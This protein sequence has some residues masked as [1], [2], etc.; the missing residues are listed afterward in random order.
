[1]LP[2]CPQNEPQR[3]VTQTDTD[4]IPITAQISLDLDKLPESSAENGAS[5]ALQLAV[6]D[7]HLC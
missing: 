7:Q 4:L 1:M 5:E 3:Y 2:R 6:E